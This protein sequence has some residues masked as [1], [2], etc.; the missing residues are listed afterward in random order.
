VRRRLEVR[1]ADAEVDDR[2][3]LTLQLIGAR[4]HLEGALGSQAFECGDELQHGVPPGL[5]V[6]VAGGLGAGAGR[7]GFTRR[8]S[9][10]LPSA[11]WTAHLWGTARGLVKLSVCRSTR[12]RRDR[13]SRARR[14]RL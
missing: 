12:P 13:A 7:A 8:A 3:A 2:P 5:L 1:L 10:W 4:Q 14:S 9:S 11:V 6:L